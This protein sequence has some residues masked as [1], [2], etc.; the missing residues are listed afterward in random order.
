M[1][2]FVGNRDLEKVFNIL[3]ESIGGE[4]VCNFG[5]SFVE[6]FGVFFWMGINEEFYG[7]VDYGNWGFCC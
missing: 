1:F 3:Y 6:E 5:Y 4:K 7:D 2:L